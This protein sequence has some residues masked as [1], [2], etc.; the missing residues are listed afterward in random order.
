MSPTTPNSVVLA[1]MP[2]PERDITDAPPLYEPGP[3]YEQKAPQ[4]ASPVTAVDT[5]PQGSH[6]VSGKSVV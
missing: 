3:S 1:G 5:N 2:P 6:N 4:S